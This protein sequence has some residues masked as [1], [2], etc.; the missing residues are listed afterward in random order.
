MPWFW[1]V[2]RGEDVPD[3]DGPVKRN[4]LHAIAI[5]LSE[6][7][8]DALQ[9]GGRRVRLGYPGCP[10]DRIPAAGHCCH[11][12]DRLARPGV[13]PWL[14]NSACSQ[15]ELLRRWILDLFSASPA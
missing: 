7:S 5:F 9:N 10:Q 12:R 6:A 3:K 11:H 8:N 14:V 2:H 15:A 1:H 13:E 4:P